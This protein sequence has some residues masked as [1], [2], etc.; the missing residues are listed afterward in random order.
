MSAQSS[1]S[2]VVVQ[3]S[4]SVQQI[5]EM[6]INQ[7]S[8]PNELVDIIKSFA[9][10]DIETAMFIKQVKSQKSTL[11]KSISVADCNHRNTGFDSH[12][13]HWWFGYDIYGDTNIYGETLQLQGANCVKC[14]EYMNEIYPDRIRCKCI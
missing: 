1:Q 12:P 5:K 10:Y 11:C 14:G 13:Y 9:F 7:F 8:V 6:I 4:L 3:P 2:V